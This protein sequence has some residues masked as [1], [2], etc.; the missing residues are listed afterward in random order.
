VWKTISIGNAFTSASSVLVLAKDYIHQ[1]FAIVLI[2]GGPIFARDQTAIEVKPATPAIQNKDLW[3]R[4]GLIHQLRIAR[5]QPKATGRV[6][7]L[8]SPNGRWN[9]SF[10]LAMPS[11]LVLIYGL[12]STVVVARVGARLHFPSDVIPGAGLGWFM[13]DY[14]Y[15]KRHNRELDRNHLRR[16][17]C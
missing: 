9:S 12:A 6:H 10:L 14:L 2:S 5:R 17:M 11:A 16:A 13:G 7:F 4:T 1:V 8:D 15:G 3:E